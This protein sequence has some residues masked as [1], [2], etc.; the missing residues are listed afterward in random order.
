MAEYVD[1]CRRM[2]IDVLPPDVNE[3]GVLFTPLADGA[4]RFGLAAIKNVGTQAMESI[5]AERA[6]RNHMKICS[7]FADASICASAT[8]A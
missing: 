1:E 4:I 7:I 6:E 3:S 5:L 8:S 2:G